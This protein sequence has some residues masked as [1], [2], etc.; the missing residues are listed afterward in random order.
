MQ[1]QRFHCFLLLRV[2]ARG[3]RSR[4]LRL[5]FARVVA[6]VQVVCVPGRGG[7]RHQFVPEIINPNLAALARPSLSVLISFRVADVQRL[8][9]GLLLELRLVAG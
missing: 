1:L 3:R 2:V 6:R 9:V 4:L 7:C 5:R 8:V